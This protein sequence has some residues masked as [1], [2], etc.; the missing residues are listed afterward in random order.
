MFCGGQGTLPVRLVGDSSDLPLLE[1]GGAFFHPFRFMDCFPLGSICTVPTGTS[2][3]R[4]DEM[5]WDEMGWDV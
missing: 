2:R 4:W 5:G 1:E 3:G